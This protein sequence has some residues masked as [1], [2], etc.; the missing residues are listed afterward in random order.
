MRDSNPR[1]V[2]CKT[3]ILAAELTEH[4]LAWGELHHR[5]VTYQVTALLTE[6]QASIHFSVEPV[7]LEPTTFGLQG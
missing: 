2:V 6:L 7:G 5:P 4:W 1:R 3:T